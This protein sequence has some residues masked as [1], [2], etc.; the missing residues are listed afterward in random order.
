MAPE[1]AADEFLLAHRCVACDM[2]CCLDYWQRNFYLSDN[3]G[4]S[5]QI[6]WCGRP[7]NDKVEF[8]TYGS[9]DNGTYLVQSTQLL[10]IDTQLDCT[11]E[12][13]QQILLLR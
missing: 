7:F 6:T 10:P 2:F 5:H 1:S 4:W 8:T 3:N 9:A 11:V 12:M 13:A